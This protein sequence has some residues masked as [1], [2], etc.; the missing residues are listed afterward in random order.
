ML[1][2]VLV[3]DAALDGRLAVVDQRDQDSTWQCDLTAVGPLD[4]V[5]LLDAA[6][7]GGPVW[8]DDTQ[9]VAT[10]APEL[11]YGGAPW[12]G[13]LI[14]A[15]VP[16]G[17]SVTVRLSD[18]VAG[19]SMRQIFATELIFGDQVWLAAGEEHR[20]VPIRPGNYPASVWADGP[21]PATVRHYC[22]VLGAWSP[23][24]LGTPRPEWAPG[25]GLQLRFR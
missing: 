25:P 10:D 6:W 19:S 13:L 22:I 16:A 15:V 4:E 14:R 12:P 1:D 20:T 18:H 11:V 3:I 17:E 2:G 8:D 9:W 24:N 23:R 7:Q 21:T 5:E